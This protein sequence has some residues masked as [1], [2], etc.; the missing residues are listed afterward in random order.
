MELYYYSSYQLLDPVDSSAQ[1]NLES[2]E[3]WQFVVAGKTAAE[4]KPGTWF[5]CPCQLSAHYILVSFAPLFLV[6]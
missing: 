6:Q 5:S 4:I 3:H 1:E 2:V